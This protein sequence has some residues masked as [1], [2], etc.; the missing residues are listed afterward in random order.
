M[1]EEEAERDRA[2]MMFFSSVWFVF[3]G[4]RL[5]MAMSGVL[6]DRLSSI[7]SVIGKSKESKME[8]EEREREKQ[9]EY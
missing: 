3:V 1:E 9:N 4:M 6:V 8:R 5:V 2:P 7:V